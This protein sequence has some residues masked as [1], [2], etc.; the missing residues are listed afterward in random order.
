MDWKR[1]I[2]YIIIL[3]VPL[4]IYAENTYNCVVL[5][6]IEGEMIEFRLSSNPRLSQRNDTV[7]LTNDKKKVELILTEIKKI[8]FSSTSDDIKKMG[9][10]AK[11]RIEVQEG[12]VNLSNFSPGEY[13]YI[14]NLSGQLILKRVIT[15]QGT[16]IIPFT[17]I[18]KG[19]VI[20]KTNNQSLKIKCQ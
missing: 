5:E 19:I 11:G 12:R 6:T 15:S 14:F 4:N 1:K 10:A 9:D 3:L 17:D 7:I 13:V 18:P 20:I 16:L 8:F 2:L